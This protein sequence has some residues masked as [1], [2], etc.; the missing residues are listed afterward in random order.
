MIDTGPLRTRRQGKLS[1]KLAG[2]IALTLLVIGLVALH[3][4][5]PIRLLYDYDRWCLLRAAQVGMRRA[6][7]IKRLGPPEHV[8]RSRA[9]FELGGGY[10]FVPTYPVEKEVLEYY[11]G[12]WKI[13]V[14][15]G[16]DDRVTRAFVART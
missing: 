13:F 16:R 10:D 8:A 14:Y 11:H 1:W 4:Y 9:E 12:I 2:Y 15:V 6:E 7:V 5:N 3:L